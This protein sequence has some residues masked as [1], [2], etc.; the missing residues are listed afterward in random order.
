MQMKYPKTRMKKWVLR[1]KEKGVFPEEERRLTKEL[2]VSSVMARLLSLRG[3]R[4][5]VSAERFL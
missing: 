4:D 5:P 2:G 1:E 3:Y